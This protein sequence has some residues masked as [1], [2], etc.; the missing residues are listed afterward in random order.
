MKYILCVLLLVNDVALA[1]AGMNAQELQEQLKSEAAEQLVFFASWCASCKKHMTQDTLNKS[2]FIAAF[3]EQSAAD[4]AFRAFLGE[5]NLKRCI[6]DRDG[7][8]AAAY[9]VK[10][11]PVIRSLKP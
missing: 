9:G 1:C 4:K 8:I 3:D 2:Y 10:G 6:W 7:S 5:S 11:L